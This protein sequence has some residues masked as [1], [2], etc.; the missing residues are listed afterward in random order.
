M[1]AIIIAAGKGSRLNPHTNDL[2]KCLL[3][4]GDKTALDYIIE[5]LKPHGIDRIS[6]VRGYEADKFTNTNLRYYM[7]ED[8]E[9]NN[10]LHSLMKAREEF[11]GDLIISY[12]DIWYNPTVVS[13]LI[14]T[15]GDFVV[16]VDTNW[17]KGYEGRT[18][19]PLSEAENA[20]HDDSGFIV[21]IGKHLDESSPGEFLGV[22]RLT[23]R[24]AQIFREEF[25]KLESSLDP[26]EPFVQAKE[27]R[28][29]YLTDFI[30][31]LKN[32]GHPIKCSLHTEKWIEMDTPQDYMKAITM[33]RGYQ[34][35]LVG[36][37]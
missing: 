29:A 8:Y 9:N 36:S 22:M 34:G 30:Q 11:D 5:N 19:H 7:N 20:V 32:I 1:K 35:E 28:K 24:G 37:A 26:L 3:P 10:I 6:V 25:E 33:V 21:E 12:S 2:P 23:K 4:L 18:L 15:P 16:S 14:K 17:K 27:W 31:H 13:E